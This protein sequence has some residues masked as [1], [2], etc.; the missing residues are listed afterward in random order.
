MTTA[1]VEVLK[2]M[3]GA[4]FSLARVSGG[5]EEEI[6][7]IYDEEKAKFDKNTPDKLEDL[8]D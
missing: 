3:I 2:L 1:I 5:T 7:A 6:Q 4:Y 8:E